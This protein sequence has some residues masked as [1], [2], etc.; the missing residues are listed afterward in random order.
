M[1]WLIGSAMVGIVAA[2]LAGRLMRGNG[3]GLFGNIVAGVLGAVPGG[4]ALHLAGMNLGAGLTGRLIVAF[5]GA[6]IVL[7]LVHLFTGRRGGNR[8]WS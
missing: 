2:W 1:I 5:I 8:L 3:L 6:T 7:F 4:Y